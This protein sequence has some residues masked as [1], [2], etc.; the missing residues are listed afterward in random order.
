MHARHVVNIGDMEA[1]RHRWVMKTWNVENLEPYRTHFLSG[2][3]N[4]ADE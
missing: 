4:T 1:H 2:R 3:I